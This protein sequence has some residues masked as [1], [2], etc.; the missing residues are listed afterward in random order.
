MPLRTPLVSGKQN[1]KNHCFC[2]R[3]LTT[4]RYK[5][6]QAVFFNFGLSKKNQPENEATS[7]HNNY[8]YQPIRTELEQPLIVNLQRHLWKLFSAPFDTNLVNINIY[9]QT[10]GVTIP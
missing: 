7:F 6:Y 3:F 2:F 1:V 4:P 10:A 8:L 9:T 5:Q